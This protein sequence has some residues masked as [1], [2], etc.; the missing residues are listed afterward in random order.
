MD[1]AY[2]TYRP[3]SGGNVD[4]DPASAYRRIKALGKGAYGEAVLVV[5]R[6]DMAKFVIKEVQ[7]VRANYSF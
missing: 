1:E 5:R 3:H 7:V 2:S 4:Q 6:S